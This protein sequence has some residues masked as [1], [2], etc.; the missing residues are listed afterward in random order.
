MIKILLSLL[1]LLAAPALSPVAPAYHPDNDLSQ[2]NG[3]RPLLDAH[4]CYPYDGEYADRIDR[5]LG[6]GFPVGIEQDIAPY[7]DPK[8]GE[9]IAK[10]T[11]RSQAN[12]SDP[13][14]RAY[15]FEKV[16]PQ[17]EKALK[18]GDKSKWPLIVLHF[19]FKNN[20]APTLRAVWKLLGEYQDWIT[21]TDK[22]ADDNTLGKLNWGPLLVLTEDNPMQEQ[23][24]YTKLAVG[25]KLRLF[26]SAHLN[27]KVLE[28]LNEKQRAH[29]LAHAAPDVLL[30]TP[31]T[32][33]RRWWNNSWWEVEEGGQQ[34]AG[35]WTETDNSRLQALVDHAH[36]MGYMIR[37]YT[38]DG[39]PPAED[40]GWGNYYNFGS[41]AAVKKRWR[42]AIN[43]GVDM[44]ATNQ[45]EELRR[46]MDG[47]GVG[48][49]L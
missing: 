47:S 3:G 37:F 12:G 5:A 36:R 43:D 4:N 2:V 25:D 34:H 45:Y 10:V 35:D 7:T 15:F 32:N 6:T 44:I 9:V 19:D 8:T 30:A 42:A 41:L 24:F 1:T 29:A 14:L 26:G 38:L 13:T 40:Q 33:Y 17:I 22:T 39:F 21:T 27:E 46:F 23:I 16:R 48:H 49:R 18:D 20:S 28:G 31:A 11:H